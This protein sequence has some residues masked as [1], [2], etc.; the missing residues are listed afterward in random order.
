MPI[1]MLKHSRL[2]HSNIR[3]L[4]RR[5]HRSGINLK[6]VIATLR[7]GKGSFREVES[8]AILLDLERHADVAEHAFLLNSFPGEF[9][10]M[11]WGDKDTFPIAFAS[12]GKADQFIQITVPPGEWPL[13][14]CY[15]HSALLRLA[16]RISSCKSP[17]LRVSGHYATSMC[18]LR[19]LLRKR[20]FGSQ[21]SNVHMERVPSAAAGQYDW[22]LPCALKQLSKHPYPFRPNEV[23][24]KMLASM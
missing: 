18:I 16:R 14:N 6:A 24:P 8:G 11:Y 22:K 23:F 2:L 15:V 7:E 20:K 4:T 3:H 12:A 1:S 17:S 9:E 21:H 10:S 19:S 5:Q 13:C